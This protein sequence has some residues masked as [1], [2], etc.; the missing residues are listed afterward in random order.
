L[1]ETEKLDENWVGVAE[2]SMGASSHVFVFVL[3]HFVG[4]EKKCGKG[5]QIPLFRVS[6]IAHE[7]CSQ[8]PG[9]S[10]YVFK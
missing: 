10:A 2:G 1:E 5:S 4:P 9:R 8:V 7:Q 6:F 3:F